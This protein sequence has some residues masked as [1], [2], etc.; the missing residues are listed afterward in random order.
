LRCSVPQAWAHACGDAADAALLALWERNRSGFGQHCDVSAQVSVMQA[1]QSLML[2]HPFG[3]ALGARVGGGM[4]LGPLDIRLVWPCLDGT[5]TITFLFGASAGP[6]SARLF[7]W[8]YEEGFC[9]EATR[10]KDWVG[11]GSRLS[12]GE[13]PISEFDRVKDILAAFCLTKTK[14]ELF[15][16][17]MARKLLIA[18]ASTI[19]DV[20]TNEQFLVRRYWDEVEHPELGRAIRYPGPFVQPS[21]GRLPAMSRPPRLGEHTEEVLGA[22]AEATPPAPAASAATAAAST[23]PGPAVASP[24]GEDELRAAAPLAGLKV[25]DFM[26]SLAGPSISRVLADYGATVVRIESSKRIEMGRTLNPFWQDKNDVEA[27]G[28]F[29]NVNAGK[30]GVCLDLNSESGKAVVADLV[31]WA[32]VVTESYSPRAMARWGL[33]YAHLREINPDIVMLSSCLMGQSGPLASLAGFGNLAAAIAG[34]FHTTGW[35]DRTC[36]GPYGGYTDYLS[37]RFAVVALLAALEQRRRTGQGCYLDFSQCESA[38]WALGP[39]FADYEVNGR[40]WERAGNADRNHCP[41]LVTPCAGDDRWMAIVCED[42]EQWRALCQVAQFGPDAAGW[43]TAERLAR[44]EEIDGMVSTW[45]A[46]QHGP[47]LAEKL[48]A[49]GVPAHV[50]ADS[51]DVW[52]DPQL[53]ARGHWAWVDHDLFGPIPVEASRFRLSRTPAPPIRSAPTL[54]QHVYEVLHELLGYDDD[55]IGDLAGEGVLE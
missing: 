52:E 35:P 8:L 15:D 1:T 20:F 30:L 55:R 18:P 51:R 47:R 24:L 21:T 6:F 48:Q 22:L 28:L 34:F 32:D 46:S 53:E 37:P 44:R 49:A 45:T 39:A 7:E 36:V 11:F 2:N 9:D 5:V 31:R 40:I 25:L 54:G 14:Q 3:V 13:D 26:W 50:L 38:M 43:S 41:H 10:D 23:A 4:R 29:N 27:S 16:A 17:A 33:D 19:A 42:D 12:L